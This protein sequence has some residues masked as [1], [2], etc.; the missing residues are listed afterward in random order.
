MVI[1]EGNR[2]VQ[3]LVSYRKLRS[4]GARR[5]EWESVSFVPL[6]GRHGWEAKT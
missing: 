6:I 5:E 3:R 1:P 2:E 4:G